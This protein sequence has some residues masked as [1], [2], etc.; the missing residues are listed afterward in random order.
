[1]EVELLIV[2]KPL[3]IL[4]R[5]KGCHL[6]ADLL[7][8]KITP[9]VKHKLWHCSAVVL[10]EQRGVCPGGQLAKPALYQADGWVRA[11]GRTK[12]LVK[13]C[14]CTLE[15]MLLQVMTTRHREIKADGLVE[16]M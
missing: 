4:C 12:L 11:P 3:I 9:S 6:L 16:R 5:S 7:Q 1:M 10:L 14:D 15:L 2:Y 8:S 13:G